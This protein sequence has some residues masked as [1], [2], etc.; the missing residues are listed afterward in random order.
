MPSDTPGP[1]AGATTSQ[2][3][4]E[5]RNEP[6]IDTIQVVHEEPDAAHRDRIRWGPVWSGIVVAISTFILLQLALVAVGLFDA[7]TPGTAD[8]VW[9][10]IAAGLAF[11]LGGVTSGAT[12]LWRRIEDGLLH[13]ILLWAVALVVLIALSSL[14]SGLA[15]GAIDT[16]EVFDEVTQTDVEDFLADDAQDAAGQAL[17]ALTVALIAAAAGGALGAKLWPRVDNVPVGRRPT[18]RSGAPGS[19]PPRGD[20]DG[21]TP[22]RN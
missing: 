8:A 2:R 16:T 19:G 9:S 5:H 15:L 21:R 13:G 11:F 4:S 3:H 22:R 20:G 7:E 1:R 10:A 12:A 17:L 14:G 18:A 6:E